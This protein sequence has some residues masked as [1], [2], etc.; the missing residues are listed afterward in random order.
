MR[1]PCF[2]RTVPIL[3]RGRRYGRRA[4]SS[5]LIAAAVVTIML[6][7]P[8]LAYALLAGLPPEAGLYAF[9]AP[10]LLHAI[11]GTSRTLAVGPVA[12]VSLTM[13]A[14]VLMCSA[15]NE[16]DFSAIEALA[17]LNHRLGELGIALHLLEVKGPVMDRLVRT[18]L[19]ADLTGQVFQSQSDAGQA[20]AAD[21]IADRPAA[22]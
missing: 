22:A 19:I 7:P 18:R 21:P 11:F 12:V 1:V 9:I 20:L 8:S 4:L 5:D 6:I 2:A 15:V 16:I 14:A 10:I 17:G 13:A 3:D